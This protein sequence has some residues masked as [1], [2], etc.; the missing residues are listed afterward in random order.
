MRCAP[1]E[2]V[3]RKAYPRTPDGRYFVAKRR[4]WRCTNPGLPEDQRRTLVRDLMKARRAVRF[5]QDETA[6]REARA[7]VHAAKVELGER[8]PVWWNDG[9]P[10]VNEKHPKNTTYADWWA[11]LGEAEREA[12]S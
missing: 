10:D 7:A 9:A 4:L 6:E 5:A 1:A 11:S 3:P 2:S 12:G 8:G